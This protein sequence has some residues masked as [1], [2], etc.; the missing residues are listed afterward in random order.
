MSMVKKKKEMLNPHALALAAAIVTLV[1]DIAGFLWHGMMGQPSM[2]GYMYPGFWG[3][4]SMLLIG[5]VASV[6][7]AYILG[8]LFALVYNR[9]NE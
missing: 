1:M 9:F 7:G 5:L 2:M 4:P 8:Y 6:V 3:M